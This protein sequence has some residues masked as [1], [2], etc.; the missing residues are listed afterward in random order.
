MQV[1]LAGQDSRA[2]SP[3]QSSVSLDCGNQV[4]PRPCPAQDD[5][6]QESPIANPD[7]DEAPSTDSVEQ[8][9]SRMTPTARQM[10]DEP[11]LTKAV[12]IPQRRPSDRARG[13]VRAYAPDLLRC[14]IDQAT[15]L[16]FIDDLNRSVASN[17]AVQAVDLAGEAVGAVPGSEFVGAPIIG[18]ALQVA[19]GAYKEINARRG[20]AFLV[21][22][23]SSLSPQ[24]V[25]FFFDDDHEE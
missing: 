6:S 10:R 22:L 4:I 1:S 24:I 11:R 5:E 19:A 7:R 13:F 17:P 8:S 14:G 21:L 12:V 15:F 20:Y 16:R 18:T 2:Q 25:D 3:H 23:I 9:A